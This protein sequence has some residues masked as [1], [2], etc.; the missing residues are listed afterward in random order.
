MVELQGEKRKTKETRKAKDKR[1]PTS[2]MGLMQKNSKKKVSERVLYLFS[3]GSWWC[4]LP[5]WTRSLAEGFTWSVSQ[6]RPKNLKTTVCQM[7]LVAKWNGGRSLHKNAKGNR[8]KKDVGTPKRQ[9]S[10]RKS[11]RLVSKTN[12]GLSKSS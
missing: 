3:D 4:E 2:V 5:D 12:R 9:T 11:S 6:V 8:S 7:Q 10:N 1:N